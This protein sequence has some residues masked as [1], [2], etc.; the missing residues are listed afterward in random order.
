M[1]G[2]NFLKE[3]LRYGLYGLYP[4]YKMYIEPIIAFYSMVGHAVVASVLNANCTALANQSMYLCITYN[5]E[6]LL[7]IV[8]KKVGLIIKTILKDVIVLYITPKDSIV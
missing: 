6:K 1:L 8:E 2:G 4:K 3:R 5:I 7:L